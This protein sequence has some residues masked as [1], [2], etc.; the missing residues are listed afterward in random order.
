MAARPLPAPTAAKKKPIKAPPVPPHKRQQPGHSATAMT[1][2]TL[3]FETEGE[4]DSI[5]TQLIQ[6]RVSDTHQNAMRET[7]F[8]PAQTST[9]SRVQEQLAGHL[10]HGS[11]SEAKATS[12]GG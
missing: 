5:D 2:D 6:E 3:E 1:T 10:Q 9:A 7:T 4:Y 8:G 11:P 12:K